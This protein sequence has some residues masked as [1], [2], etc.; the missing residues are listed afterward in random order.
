M[1][2]VEIPSSS[3]EP[4]SMSFNS[5]GDG[6]Y[7]VTVERMVTSGIESMPAKINIPRARIGWKSMA[8][9]MYLIPVITEILTDDENQLWTMIIQD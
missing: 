8:G 4:K 9:V 6:T 7:A 5:N 1:K 2:K 3:F